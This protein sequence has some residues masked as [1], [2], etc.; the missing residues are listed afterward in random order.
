MSAAT[1]APV[2]LREAELAGWHEWARPWPVAI[3][4]LLAAGMTA[5]LTLSA[6]VLVRPGWFALFAAYNVL[7]F[8]AVGLLWRRRR[9][10]SHV[11]L[12]LLALGATLAVVA[13]QGTSWPLGFSI[14]VLFD[15]IS[16]LLAWY[17][18]LGYPAVRLTRFAAATFGY[19]VVA[20]AVGFVP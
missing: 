7:A 20:V 19:G 17:L 4:A 10:H 15:P 6:G 18:L 8:A 3:A 9:P 2:E 11:G 14:G 5:A 12:L 16:A 13:L 1:T